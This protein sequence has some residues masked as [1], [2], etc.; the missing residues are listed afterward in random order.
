MK[1]IQGSPRQAA[2]SADFTQMCGVEMA[3]TYR[4][5]RKST[6]QWYF[7]YC[8]TL[9]KHGLY[10]DVIWGNSITFTQPV[11]EKLWTSD[12]KTRFQIPLSLTDLVSP[13]L[14]LSWCRH[15]FIGQIIWYVCQTIACQRYFS[16]LSWR[17]GYTLSRWPKE[18]LQGLVKDLT[19]SIWNRPRHMGRTCT[20]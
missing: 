18:A 5:S 2:L 11:S 12:G 7:Q 20:K 19:E 17:E 4:L 15:R 16:M 14:T 9:V 8:Y 3:L 13:A 6:K 1:C 10:I